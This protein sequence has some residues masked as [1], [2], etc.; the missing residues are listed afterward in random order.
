MCMRELG[1][2]PRLHVHPLSAIPLRDRVLQRER[3]CRSHPG[4]A[5]QAAEPHPPVALQQLAVT[6]EL[7]ERYELVDIRAHMRGRKHL[8]SGNVFSLVMRIEAMA[9]REG[10]PG[11]IVEEIVSGLAGPRHARLRKTLLKW[12]AL[13]ARRHEVDLDFLQDEEAV[14][15]HMATG[16]IRTFA[17]ECFAR[18]FAVLRAQGRQEGIERGVQHE[19]NLLRRLAERKFGAQ[20]GHRVAG[21]LAT[22]D[23]P[24]Q[25]E[26]V[27]DWIID[28][29]DGD[30]L[31]ARIG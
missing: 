30:E 17:D 1:R 18:R 4:D 24:A 31:L 29:E 25:L 19:R 12:F 13:V 15:H 26:D 20:V 2:G 28:C 21:M 11:A 23:D 10:E 7:F 9:D 22:I 3:P 27:G 14:R 16:T 8:P 6:T 5:H